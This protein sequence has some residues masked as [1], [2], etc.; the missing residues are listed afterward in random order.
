VQ[1][2]AQHQPRLAEEY[3]Q[4][5]DRPASDDL[6]QDS[7]QHAGNAA[8]LRD[9]VGKIARDASRLGI[10]IIE[11]AGAVQSVTAMSARHVAMFADVSRTASETASTNQMVVSALRKTEASCANAHTV[12]ETTNHLVESSSHDIDTMVSSTN[13]I[14]AEIDKFSRSLS[15]VEEMTDEIGLIARQTNLLALNAAIEAARAGD[16]G[17]GFAV[18]AA[19]IRALS[20]QTSGATT[21]IQNMLKAIL[22]GIGQLILSGDE[23][24]GSA[25]TVKARTHETLGSFEQMNVV[26]NAI[27]ASAS[28]VSAA[29]NMIEEKYPRLISTLDGMSDEVVSAHKALQNTTM[30]LDGIVSLSEKMIQSTASTGVETED[31]IWIEKVCTAAS[32][33]SALLQGAVDTGQIE[34]SALFDKRLQAIPGSNPLQQM[35]AF[36]PI[37]DRLFPKV[38]EAVVQSDS[39]I[40]FCAA[41]TPQGYLPTHNAKFSQVQKPGD[42]VWNTANARN[43]RVFDDRVGLAAGRSTEPFLVQTYRRDMGGGNFVLMKDISAP[44]FV[45]NRH[46][47]GLRLAVAI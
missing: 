31:S 29:T 13:R 42:V 36:T 32:D 11:I 40:V 35:A 41:I 19:E 4:S 20:I 28:Q 30:Q 46:W 24:S 47:G 2:A 5:P 27:L 7:S 22:E 18:V 26:I 45:G 44:I 33:L 1:S 12:L 25:N 38:Q 17:K 9:S 34:M 3:L 8:D 16:A 6:A 21:A 10:D 14:T 39:R 37:T 43:R 23:I 15:Q